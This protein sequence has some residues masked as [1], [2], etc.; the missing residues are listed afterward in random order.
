MAEQKIRSFFERTLK[1]ADKITFD[2]FMDLLERKKGKIDPSKAMKI[3][4]YQD[5]YDDP[6]WLKGCELLR[7]F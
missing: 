7:K 5:S 6:E 4:S 2:M 3:L 1:V